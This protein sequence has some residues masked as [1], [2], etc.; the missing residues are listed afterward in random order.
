MKPKALTAN[1]LIEIRRHY[2]G[3]DSSCEAISGKVF[4]G[5][6]D[7]YNNDNALAML[8]ESGDKLKFDYGQRGRETIEQ[9]MASTNQSS[10]FDPWGAV[11]GEL[12]EFVGY[13]AW[14][15]DDCEF[16]NLEWEKI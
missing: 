3:I 8:S 16:F 13:F 1:Q 4:I 14:S 6:K 11:A 7:D 2:S 10:E 15:N 9:M 5:H 12:V